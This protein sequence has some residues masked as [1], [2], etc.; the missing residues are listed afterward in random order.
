MAE[1]TNTNT[2]SKYA[3][4]IQKRKEEQEALSNDAKGNKPPAQAPEKPK[5]KPGRPKVKTAPERTVN[6]AIPVA[7]LEMIEI[8]K[9]KYNGNLTAYINAVIAADLKAHFKEYQTIYNLINDK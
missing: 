9:A 3:Q 6:V 4:L 8:A 7:T 1:N 2:G 5:R